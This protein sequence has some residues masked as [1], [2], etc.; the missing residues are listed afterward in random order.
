MSEGG[1]TQ[2]RDLS[3][4]ENHGTITGAQW[5][6]ERNG[7]VIRF[8]GID[9]YIQ[10]A[11]SAS[12]NITAPGLTLMGWV[13]RSNAGTYVM[14]I[15][16]RL[17]NSIPFQLFWG[18]SGDPSPHQIAFSMNTQTAFLKGTTQNLSGWHHIAGTYDGAN[19]RIYLDGTQDASQAQ[20]G[21]INSDTVVVSIGRDNAGT[22]S[23]HDYSNIRIYNRA[24]TASEIKDIYTS[25]R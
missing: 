19:M 13:N 18:S 3:G 24:L 23:D 17:T 21:N 12:L 8:D 14:L 15:A 4:N 2:A 9:D 6:T 22:F 20:T 1:G 16:K 25:E 10:I 11:H 7:R 5:R